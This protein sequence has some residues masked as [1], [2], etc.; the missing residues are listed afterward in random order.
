MLNISSCQ[1]RHLVIEDVDWSQIHLVFQTKISVDLFTLLDPIYLTW[2]WSHYSVIG[3]FHRLHDID[4]IY[5][6]VIVGW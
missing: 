6:L 3:W 5:C 2:P 1:S 4:Q